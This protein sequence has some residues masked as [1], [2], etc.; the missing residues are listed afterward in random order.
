MRAAPLPAAGAQAAALH[1]A[2][3]EV[4][5][6]L[7]VRGLVLE[8]RNALRGAQLQAEPL[9]GPVGQI[10]ARRFVRGQLPQTGPEAAVAA[11]FEKKAPLVFD[12]QDAVGD[13]LLLGAFRRHRQ[14]IDAPVT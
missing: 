7:A 4:E 9:R 3:P 11:P 14:F 8:A 5:C 13:R 1:A 2:V 10:A 6:D 12:G